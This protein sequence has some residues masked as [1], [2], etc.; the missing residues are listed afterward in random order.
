MQSTF[1][2]DKNTIITAMKK[3]VVS[4]EADFYKCDIQVFIHHRWKSLA[5]GLEY[6][7]KFYNINFR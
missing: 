7:Y 4:A 3:L 5:N 6:A 1:F 2:S